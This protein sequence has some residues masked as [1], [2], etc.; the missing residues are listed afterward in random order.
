MIVL[1]L[2]NFISS[3]FHPA[4]REQFLPEAF[5]R[6]AEVID[7]VVDDEE[8]VVE[9][10]VLLDGYGWVLTV[11]PFKVEVQ[12]FRDPPC[13]NLRRNFL[14]A[15]RQHEQYRIID[16]VVN[17]DD[18]SLSRTNKVG[19]EGVGI[20]YLAVVK[21]ALHRRQGGAY[22]KPD[23]L[24]GFADTLF[25]TFKPLVDGISAKEVLFQH[26]VR[27]LA[28]TCGINRIDPKTNRNDHVQV[29]IFHFS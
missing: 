8:T 28:E 1:R 16:I 20:E 22:E 21:D 23:L 15:F 13:D 19:G 9:A 14:L 18:T 4:E 11:V 7:G 25:Q 10:A 12:R 24:L 29:V 2:I 5:E 3:N 17:E 27:P 6:R 26:T